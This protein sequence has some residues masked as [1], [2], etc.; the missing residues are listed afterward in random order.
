MSAS[1]PSDDLQFS[2]AEPAALTPGSEASDAL[3][4]AECSRPIADYYFTIGSLAICASCKVKVE[5]TLAGEGTSRAGRIT[6]ALVYGFGAA[7]AGAAIWFTVSVVS[8]GYSIGIIAILIGWMVG[9]AVRAGSRGRGG[10]R[11]QV[12]AGLLTYLSVAMSFGA[13]GI[14]ELVTSSPSS[15]T[16]DSTAKSTAGANART[17]APA[18]NGRDASAPPTATTADSG[19]PRDSAATSSAP[20]SGGQLA[21]AIAVMLGF[22]FVLPIVANLSEMPSGLIG[23]AII[24]FGI[25]QAWK[26]NAALQITI[27]GPHRIGSATGRGATGAAPEPEPSA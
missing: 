7:L 27:T 26:M 17:V 24:A 4:C 1:S 5:R 18:S 9:R 6:R 22:M 3:T 13:L 10:R 21:T 15:V 23:L 2:T 14:R 25:V 8:G 11:Y 19:A 16:A 20:M 12:A